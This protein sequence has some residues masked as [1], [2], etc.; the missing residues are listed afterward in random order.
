MADLVKKYQ[1]GV[2]VENYKDASLHKEIEKLLSMDLEM[3]KQNAKKVAIDYSWEHQENK[4]IP[5]YKKFSNY[6]DNLI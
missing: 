1:I 6:L 5:V 3:L 2:V 4:M